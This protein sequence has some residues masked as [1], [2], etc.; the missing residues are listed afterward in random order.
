MGIQIIGR[1]HAEMAVLQLAAAYE[2]A[3]NWVDRYPPPLLRA[4]RKT[5][6]QAA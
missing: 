1:R 5:P 3:T 4:G 2:A 6:E